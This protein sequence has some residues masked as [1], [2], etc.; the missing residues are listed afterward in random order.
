MDT[1]APTSQ[2]VGTPPP[3]P[4]PPEPTSP[5]GVSVPTNTPPKKRFRFRSHHV[6][7]LIGAIGAVGLG[8]NRLP[9]HSIVSPLPTNQQ[10]A[11]PS[12]NVS[13]VSAQLTTTDITGATDVLLGSR[14]QTTGCKYVMDG[15]SALPDPACTPGSIFQGVT[16]AQ[17]CASGYTTK[18]VRDVPLSTKQVVYAEYGITSYSRG[19][20]EV[21]HLIALEDGGSNDIANLWPQPASP[22]PGFHQKDVLETQLHNELCSGAISFNQAWS[23]L[24]NWV[25]AYNAN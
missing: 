22:T 2:Q 5:Q 1:N 12:A 17:L 13:S 21:D 10:V 16:V 24:K 8:I 15:T 9:A 3:T 20:Y 4:V 19:E 7:I 11:T 23:E 6:I 25:Q 18:T 14:T